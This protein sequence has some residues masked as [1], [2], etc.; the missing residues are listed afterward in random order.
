[1]GWGVPQFSPILVALLRGDLT[2]DRKGKPVSLDVGRSERYTPVE[3]D[4]VVE[5]L[6]LFKAIQKKLALFVFVRE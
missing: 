2:R 5:Q 1:M 3:S 6:H 4:P